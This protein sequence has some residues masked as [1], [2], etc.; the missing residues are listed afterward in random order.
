MTTYT[1]KSSTKAHGVWNVPVKGAVDF[2]FHTCGS[3]GVVWGMPEAFLDIKRQDGAW[4]YCPNGHKWHWTGETEEERL[5]R[6]LKQE[7]DRSAA[8]IANLDQT[9]AS[10][11]ATKGHV[12]RLRNRVSSGIC[13]VQGCQRHFENLERH[14]ANKHPDYHTH[15]S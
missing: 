5:S 9:T 15:E 11:R 8:L 13:P 1:G 2:E 4:W 7:R 12:T 14:I 3:C 6:K 10:L